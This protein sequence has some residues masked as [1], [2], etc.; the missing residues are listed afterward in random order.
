MSNQLNLGALLAL[1]QTHEMR[2]AEKG[3]Y[4]YGYGKLSVSAMTDPRL[5]AYDKGVFAF[6]AAYCGDADGMC[7]CRQKTVLNALKIG[8]HTYGASV[9]HLLQYGY[10]LREREYNGPDFGPFRFKVVQNP[11]NK[12]GW[13]NVPR[14]TPAGLDTS[15]HVPYDRYGCISKLVMH[16]SRLNIREKALYAVICAIAGP[17]LSVICHKDILMKFSGISSAPVSHYTKNLTSC[18]YLERLDRHNGNRGYSASEYRIIS[19]P[20]HIP[21][22]KAFAAQDK[23]RVMKEC[24]N[25]VADMKDVNSILGRTLGKTVTPKESLDFS[26]AAIESAASV[27]GSL[28][29]TL[30]K[31]KSRELSNAIRERIAAAAP[32]DGFEIVNGRVK[33]LTAINPVNPKTPAE[34]LI[35]ELMHLRLTDNDRRLLDVLAHDGIPEEYADKGQFGKLKESICDYLEYTTVTSTEDANILREIV[36]SVTYLSSSRKKIII[37][38]KKNNPKK[39]LQ[40]V[41]ALIRNFSFQ[42][43][44]EKLIGRVKNAIYKGGVHYLP[45]YIN[46]SVWEAVMA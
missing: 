20:K 17:E 45:S 37:N 28:K 23:R 8:A 16:D 3:I 18:G 41:N 10:L 42:S 21:Y 34:E 7:T 40:K 22:P 30:S 19:H 24:K 14:Y 25:D 27:P 1:D 31:E 26:Y 35:L 5:T 32:L 6:F 4:A 11:D 46:H 13:L 39:F 12:T 9:N 29:H 38:G 15:F 2:I 33:S 43:E 36:K 44:M